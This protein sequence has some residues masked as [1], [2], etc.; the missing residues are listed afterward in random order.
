MSD[1]MTFDQFITYVKNWA[2]R[3]DNKYNEE[4]FD[5]NECLF[6]IGDLDSDYCDDEL[7][8]WG[9]IN[10]IAKSNVRANEIKKKMEFDAI[11]KRKEIETLNELNEKYGVK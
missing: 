7:T 4:K 1:K 6:S 11:M 2:T 5:I 9:T 10:I 3:E 8:R